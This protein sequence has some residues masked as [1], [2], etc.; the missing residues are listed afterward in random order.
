MEDFT[1][2]RLRVEESVAP[3]QSRDFSSLSWRALPNDRS[4]HLPHPP[5]A[6]STSSLWLNTINPKVTRVLNSSEL[7]GNFTLAQ[8]EANA[9]I[10]ANRKGS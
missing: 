5:L 9:Y 1:L 2:R 8:E 4:L 7:L 6:L 10:A 3:G